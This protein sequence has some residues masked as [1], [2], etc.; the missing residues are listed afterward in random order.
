MKKILALFLFLFPVLVFAI[1][2]I[3]P[4]VNGE[5]ESFLSDG[6]KS[7]VKIKLR[8][9]NIFINEPK[10]AGPA[11]TAAPTGADNKAGYIL[12]KRH[13]VTPIYYNS[14]PKPEELNPTALEVYVTPGEY[15]PMTLGL[16][17]LAD[18]SVAVAIP[19][20]VNEK[21]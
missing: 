12:F 13:F 11:A 20:L 10:D 17:P 5:I 4:A 2:G 19:E 16:Y 8:L 14:V 9:G 3:D 21:G 1:D 7:T 15:E 6:S 18:A